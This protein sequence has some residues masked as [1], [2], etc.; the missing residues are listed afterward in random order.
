MTS[1]YPYTWV[2]VPED[3]VKRVFRQPLREYVRSIPGDVWMPK[4]Y[5]EI[6]ERIYNFEV[7]PDDIWLVTYPKCGTTWTQVRFTIFSFDKPLKA[8]SSNN[9][10]H[11]ISDSSNFILKV[12]KVG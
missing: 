1:T 10:S 6:A 9:S 5:K 12:N 11:F 3:E 2:D 8:K 4:A 7:R